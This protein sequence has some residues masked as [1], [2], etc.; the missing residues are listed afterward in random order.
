[1]LNNIRTEGF[2]NSINSTNQ[3]DQKTN[4]TN[5]TNR[6]NSTNQINMIN[7]SNMSQSNMTQDDLLKQL[8]IA[9]HMQLIGDFTTGNIFVDALIQIFSMTLMTYLFTQI[10]TV[11]DKIG[12]MIYWL[13]C[14]M[15][16]YFVKLYENN[17]KPKKIKKQIKK[18]DIPFISDNRKINEL[19]K[20]VFWYL[21]T[22]SEI[23]YSKE[24]DLQYVYDKQLVYENSSIVKSNLVLNKIVN[25]NKIKEIKF[26]NYIIKYELDTELVT[27]YSDQEKKR[28]NYKIKLSVE[29]D[30]F[31]KSDVLEEFCQNC[32][33]KYIDSLASKNWTQLLYVNKNGKWTHSN[34]NNTRKL[35]SII[36]QDNLKSQIKDDV[37]RFIDS[38]EWY[39]SLDIPFNRGYLFYGKPGTGKTS[40][41][42]GLS[43]YFKRHMHYLMLQ[44]IKSDAE[45][46]DLFKNI[47]YKETMLVIEDIDATVEIVKSREHKIQQNQQNQQIQ[48]TTPT[49]QVQNSNIEIKQTETI[50]N[51][52]QMV[53]IQDMNNDM[54]NKH[55]ESGITLSGLLNALDGIISTPGR[56]LIMT[57]NKPEVLDEALIRPGRLDVKYKFDFCTKDQ[58]KEMYQLFFNCEAQQD[59]INQIKAQEY[60]PSHISSVF[61]RFR[62]EP[63]IA[64]DHLDDI[65]NKIQFI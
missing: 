37:K 63:Q 26:K 64:L 56:I 47:N 30:D 34:S 21:T 61:L 20:A 48:P 23:D 1:M 55:M 18:V 8:K 31:V 6:A 4:L 22:N 2:V 17:F 33:V 44:D 65:Q 29:I 14:T 10:K 40:M 27:I 24:T 36:L 49:T 13:F 35:E 7:L 59:K 42:K 32:I 3:S 25:Q 9:M 39:N 12:L 28:E 43:S 57:S 46:L 45:L 53:Q 19:Y 11:L 15:Y 58:I 60:S 50:K 51:S 16:K 54:N 52:N 41:I 62:N 38:E 5:M